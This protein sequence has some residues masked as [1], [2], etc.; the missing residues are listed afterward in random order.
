MYLEAG[1][2]TYTGVKPGRRVE[3][4]LGP[5]PLQLR[6]IKI[7][8]LGLDPSIHLSLHPPP[9]HYSSILHPTTYPSLHPSILLL[10][11]SIHPFSTTYPLTSC[12]SQ[13]H[14][15]CVIKSGCE[16]RIREHSCLCQKQ[17]SPTSHVSDVHG[18]TLG[19]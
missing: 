2:W 1:I 7:H 10:P 5:W 9:T 13:A 19:K 12:G 14:S 16:G 4:N 18:G 8:M 15:G 6:V 17:Q 3:A 11:S